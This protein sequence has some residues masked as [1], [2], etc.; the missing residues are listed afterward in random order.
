MK[1]FKLYFVI[2]FFFFFFLFFV[3]DN[4]FAISLTSSFR[5]NTFLITFFPFSITLL[6]ES[7]FFLIFL[8]NEESLF[9]FI[10]LFND[11]FSL[12]SFV[13]FTISSFIPLFLYKYIVNNS[14][15][16]TAISDVE[17]FIR[18]IRGEILTVINKR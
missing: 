11:S 18:E 17:W 8:F 14:R 12:K 6:E 4:L 13:I 7:L 9:F 1:C 15:R 2:F 5:L 3:L 16:Y 10:F